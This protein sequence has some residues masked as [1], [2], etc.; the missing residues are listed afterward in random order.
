MTVLTKI[1][2]FVGWKVNQKENGMKMW[3]KYG[4]VCGMSVIA[5][6]F[7]SGCTATSS[8]KQMSY[9]D[10]NYF[11]MDCDKR[12]QQI[13]MLQSMESTRDDRL[14]ARLRVIFRPWEHQYASNFYQGSGRT[15]AYIQYQIQDLI[16]FCPGKRF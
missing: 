14:F 6:I 1:V 7:C 10:I 3:R 8:S 15:D 9:S 2:L 12:E 11:Q 4:L 13:K 16:N 5:V